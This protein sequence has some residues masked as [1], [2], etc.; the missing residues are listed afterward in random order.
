MG[1]E[2]GS[3]RLT[4][5]HILI[6]SKKTKTQFRRWITGEQGDFVEG[7]LQ[8]SH[9]NVHKAVFGQMPRLFG[10][11][12]IHH[13]FLLPAQL[14]LYKEKIATTKQLGVDS[15]LRHNGQHQEACSKK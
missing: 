7:A 2:K 9:E 5:E 12:V 4:T 15:R 1:N 10:V 6:E 8:F 11:L 13:H 14:H 3:T